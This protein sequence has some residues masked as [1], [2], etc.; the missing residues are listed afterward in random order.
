MFF[1]AAASN[2]PVLTMASANGVIYVQ[3]L[4]EMIG[5]I[6]IIIGGV[7]AAVDLARIKK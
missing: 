5:W 2:L 3:W 6:V 1:L 4:F 7:W